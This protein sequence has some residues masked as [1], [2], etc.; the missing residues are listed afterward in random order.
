[1][2]LKNKVVLV[3][4]GTR[5]IGQA[6]VEQCAIE[7]ATVLF[8]YRSG[9][10][11]GAALEQ[12]LKELKY[13]VKVYY[14][15]VKDMDSIRNVVDEATNDFERID[16]VVNNAGITKDGYMM[17]MDRKNWDDVIETNLG[18]MFNTCK[19]VMP[20]MLRQRGG[21]IVN[22]ASVSGLIGVPGQSNYCAAK[23]GILGMT[24]SLAKEVAA[25]KIRVNAVAP[26]YI[27]T[28][29]LNKVPETMKNMYLNSIPAK[30][31]GKVEEVAK[32][33]VF[34]ASDDSSYITGH[35]LVIDGG[36]TE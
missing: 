21:A 4:G 30:R 31:F 7:G 1:M 25:K 8:T 24:R 35:T 6:I 14:A 26:G 23:A 33:V 5:G 16:V 11:E 12:K 34:L 3:F 15:D 29:M 27:E 19:S 2:K 13:N 20:I 10:E 9:K 28:D 36:L 22:V 18:G 32:A 17:L